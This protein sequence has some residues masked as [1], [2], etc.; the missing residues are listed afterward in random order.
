MNNLKLEHILKRS[1]S[2][3]FLLIHSK[4]DNSAKIL[5]KEGPGGEY[6]RIDST[7]SYEEDLV[8]T[9]SSLEGSRSNEYLY[10]LEQ[11]IEKLSGK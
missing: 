2:L 3:N 7:D 4:G 10:T 5:H 9:D 6:K 1:K 11:K 8:Q